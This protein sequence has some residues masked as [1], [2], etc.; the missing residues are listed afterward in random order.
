M[1]NA[2]LAR[3]AFFTPINGLTLKEQLQGKKLA[4]PEVVEFVLSHGYPI[5]CEPPAHW[6][7][8]TGNG[9]GKGLEDKE[10]KWIFGFSLNYVAPDPRHPDDKRTFIHGFVWTT[11]CFERHMRHFEG[12]I[13]DAVVGR[14]W[15]ASDRILIEV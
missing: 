4:G 14:N 6:E 15:F 1:T 8:P 2:G 11:A 10:T 9:W 5:S 12:N 13:L 3:I 7:K